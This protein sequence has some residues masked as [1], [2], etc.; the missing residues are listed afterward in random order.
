MHLLYPLN[1]CSLTEPKL[2]LRNFEV[3][4]TVEEKTNRNGEVKEA[5]A[6]RGPDGFDRWHIGSHHTNPYHPY[7]KKEQ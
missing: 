4:S 1:T 5:T 2:T 3:K 7:H 6:E